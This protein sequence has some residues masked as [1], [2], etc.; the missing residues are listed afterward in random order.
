MYITRR[1]AW[2]VANVHYNFFKL[3][4]F[5]FSGFPPGMS[6]RGGVK[7]EGESGGPLPGEKFLIKVLKMAYF[8]W[9]DSKIWNILLFYFYPPPPLPRGAE[10]VDPNQL[11]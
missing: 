3:E 7:K 6:E 4:Y 5:T 9:N 1:Q 11:L 2:P 8:N 10:W